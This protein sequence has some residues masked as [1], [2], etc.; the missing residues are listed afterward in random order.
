MK[1]VFL[2]NCSI[3]SFPAL[4]RSI[5]PISTK[6]PNE[7]QHFHVAW[8]WSPVKELIMTSTPRPD[9]SWRMPS[10]KEVSRELNMLD[11]L[12]PKVSMRYFFFSSV[13]TVVNIYLEI[14]KQRQ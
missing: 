1:V 5:L 7:A 8:S 12:R 2:R 13:D 9:V 6:R 3:S 14:S 4:E 10:R 11:G